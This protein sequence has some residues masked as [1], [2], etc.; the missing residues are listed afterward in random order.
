MR[1][2]NIKKVAR[3][4]IAS[5]RR[6]REVDGCLENVSPEENMISVAVQRHFGNSSGVGCQQT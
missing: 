5:D 1:H 2:P 3:E 4:T 6:F